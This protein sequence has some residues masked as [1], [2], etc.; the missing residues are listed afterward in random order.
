MKERK[1]KTTG[2]VGGG[3]NIK[4]TCTPADKTPNI[5][6]QEEKS[7]SLSLSLRAN[8]G[9]LSLLSHSLS[10]L[11]SLLTLASSKEATAW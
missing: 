7:F 9:H 2:G 1:E 4:E 6:I 11:F 8:D 3:D 5:S 10:L